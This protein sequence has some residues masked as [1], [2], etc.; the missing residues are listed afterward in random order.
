M[1]H[2]EAKRIVQEHSAR[3]TQSR[4]RT[5]AGLAINQAHAPRVSGA[6]G[7]VSEGQWLVLSAFQMCKTEFQF[8]GCF[9]TSWVLASHATAKHIKIHPHPTLNMLFGPENNFSRIF[10]N[11]LLK[12][13]GTKK[14]L[15]YRL[16][17]ISR[18]SSGIV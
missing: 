7:E 1:R 8:R 3:K 13:S 4:D 6:E 11:L 5:Q 16:A 17:T 2:R 12:L 9:K 10:L 14:H 15:L 18:Q